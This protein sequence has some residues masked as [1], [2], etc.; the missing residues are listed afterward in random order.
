MSVTYWR[1]YP[2][3][4]PFEALGA[5]GYMPPGAV[6][7]ERPIPPPRPRG[8][9]GTI[10]WRD[11][12]PWDVYEHRPW[13]EMGFGGATLTFRLADRTVRVKGPWHVFPGH[14][15]PEPLRLQYRQR[16]VLATVRRYTV[17][18]FGSRGLR[19]VVAD[20]QIVGP[21][22]APHLLAK[23]MAASLDRKLHVL[24]YRNPGTTT[25]TE[26]P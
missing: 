20:V 4:L 18:G 16:V 11:A 2:N 15:V 19:G 10:F 3:Q 14:P 17:E 23:Q 22:S 9:P 25:W 12:A 8:L 24:V 21:Y 5:D 1:E 7:H 26:I 6:Y 13:D